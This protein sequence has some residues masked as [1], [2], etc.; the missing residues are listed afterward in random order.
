MTV[1][2]SNTVIDVTIKPERGADITRMI[3]KPTCIQVFA[4]SPTGQVTNSRSSWGDSLINWIDGYPGGWQVL[5]PNAGAEREWGGI[6]QGYHGEASLAAW[7]VVS[8]QETFCELETFLLTAPLHLRRAIEI[9]GPLLTVSDRITNLSPDETQFRFCHHPAFGHHFLD[10]FSYLD[11][12][13]GL[14]IA[15]TD[16]PGTLA[17]PHSSGKLSNFLPQGPRENTATLPGPHSADSLVGA[18]VELTPDR[19]GDP[20]VSATLV[21]PTKGLSARLS[22]DAT[23][24][25]Y[26]WVWIEAH[27]KKTWPWFQRMYAVAI[28]PANSLPGEGVSPT[29]H[30]RGGHGASLAP[31]AT[32][33]TNVSLFLEAH[34]PDPT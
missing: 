12:S 22:W 24:F 34:S 30:L 25:P 32:L 19:D 13:A 10:E 3:H 6:T 17:S 11:I 4:E 1:R 9:K 33:T 28:E 27:A 8:Q 15:D 16:D 20:T 26:A 31:G 5:I 23:V 7:T 2:L 21:S 14:F 18:L 29:G